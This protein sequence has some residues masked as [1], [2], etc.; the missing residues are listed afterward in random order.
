MYVHI[1]ERQCAS[2]PIIVDLLAFSQKR[3]S[4]VY[5]GKQ[6]DNESV[7]QEENHHEHNCSLIG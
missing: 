7:E 4:K 5:E 6:K 3:D 1:T 2:A